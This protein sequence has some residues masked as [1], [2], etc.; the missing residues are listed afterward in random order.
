MNITRE[1]VAAA[2]VGTAGMWWLGSALLRGH[3]DRWNAVQRRGL[4]YAG[5]GFLF[6]AI[7]AR[8]LQGYG[9]R[10]IAVSLMGTLLAM[11]GM[12][13]LVRERAAIR[14]RLA[15]GGTASG[16]TGGGEGAERGDPL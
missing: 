10:G 9:N 12:L 3:L 4:A 16:T 2:V 1:T 13:T 11:R 5:T 15:A 6:V 14:E 7:A 8:W